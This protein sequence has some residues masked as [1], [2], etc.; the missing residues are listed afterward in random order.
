MSIS[1]GIIE[2]HKGSL[3]VEVTEGVTTRFTIRLPMVLAR[4]KG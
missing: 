4:A 2:R 1:D 3:S